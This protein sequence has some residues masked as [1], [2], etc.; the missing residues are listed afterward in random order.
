MFLVT[1]GIFWTTIEIT[2]YFVNDFEQYIPKNVQTFGIVIF[3]AILFTVIKLFPSKKY[4]K[5]LEFIDTKISIIIGQMLTDKKSHLVIGFNNYFDTI[6]GEIVGI[7]TLQNNFLNQIFNGDREK[8]DKK[9]ETELDKLGDLIGEYNK[10]KE[11]GNKNSYPLGTCISIGEY[12]KRYFLLAYG[13][14]GRDMKWQATNKDVIWNSLNNLW[15]E[16]KNKSH[17][18]PVAI[19]L[20]GSDLGRSGLSRKETLNLI[21]T[22]FILESK[23]HLLTE[24][25]KIYIRPEDLDKVNWYEVKDMIK[26]N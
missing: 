4:S 1:I 6:A 19:P 8:L 5:K 3:I 14:L 12:S 13:H 17:G 25:L 23:N 11:I 10:N 22:S 7:N 9:I 2:S 18:I 26:Y 16:V 20:I 15:K 24:E 21:I